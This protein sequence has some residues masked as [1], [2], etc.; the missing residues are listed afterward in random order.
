MKALMVF[1]IIFIVGTF[2]VQENSGKKK[3]RT[4]GKMDLFNFDCKKSQGFSG[5][6]IVVTTHGFGIALH[7]PKDVI[8]CI[9]QIA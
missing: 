8:Q 3:F 4:K 9:R 7:V 6:G 5:G 1:A 2:C